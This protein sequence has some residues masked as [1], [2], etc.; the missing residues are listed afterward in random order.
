MVPIEAR[1]RPVER[2][3]NRYVGVRCVVNTVHSPLLFSTLN[4]L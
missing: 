1:Q 3:G 4:Q 2:R